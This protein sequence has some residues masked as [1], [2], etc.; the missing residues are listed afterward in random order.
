M[1]DVPDDKWIEAKWAEIERRMMATEE[2]L[3]D[4]KQ[5]VFT[6]EAVCI[7]R[8]RTTFNNIASL[9]IGM[10]NISKAVNELREGLN[11]RFFGW[12]TA[13]SGA[14]FAVIVGLIATLWGVMHK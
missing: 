11:A 10:T 7:E 8:Q 5:K 12:H 2:V 14:M 9:E 4:L 3:A 1:N 6:H 13:V